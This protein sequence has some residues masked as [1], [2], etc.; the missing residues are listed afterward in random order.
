MT[1]KAGWLV[2]FA[3]GMILAAPQA[4]EAKEAGDILIRLRAVDVFPIE[5][6]AA[7][8]GTT[9]INGDT[10]LDTD[11][12]PELDFS[13][14]FTDNIAA[15]LILATSMHTASVVDSTLGNVDLGT[16]RLLP[17]TLTLQYHFLPKGKYSPYLGAGL[18]YTIFYD[19][20]GGPGNGAVEVN[21]IDYSNSWGYAFQAGI[22]I[23]VDDGWYFN[24]DMKKIFLDT[25][26]NLNNG[27][28][29][30][31][32]ADIDPWVFGAGIGYRF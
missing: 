6:G 7:D 27:A 15:E 17:P 1:A 12:I 25:D 16:V 24:V 30:V 28:A 19:K 20:V 9:V 11:F 31:D 8:D 23:Q 10:S 22:D 4:A 18:N 21:D 26:I 29:R 32:D 3:M 5:G 14:F 2:A 13:Y